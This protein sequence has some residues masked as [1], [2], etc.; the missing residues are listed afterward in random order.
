MAAEVFSD[1]KKEEA[2]FQFDDG[3][4][5]DSVS[6]VSSKSKKE[7]KAPLPLGQLPDQ[8]VNSSDYQQI[9]MPLFV[10]EASSNGKSEAISGSK[11]KDQKVVD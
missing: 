5:S 11:L 9:R 3:D 7:F 8:S 4:L 1:A 2:D 10:I 6:S